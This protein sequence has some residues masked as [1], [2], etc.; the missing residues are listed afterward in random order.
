MPISVRRHSHTML[1]EAWTSLYQVKAFLLLHTTKGFTQHSPLLGFYPPTSM[2]GEAGCSHHC[3]AEDTEACGRDLS[4]PVEGWEEEASRSLTGTSPL[5][6]STVD[7]VHS[8]ISLDLGRILCGNIGNVNHTAA[9][10]HI[11]F[12][13][14]SCICEDLLVLTVLLWAC[15]AAGS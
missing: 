2:Q 14:Y 11:Y 6:S 1:P 9:G 3:S 12:H 5:F 7:T 15:T 8:G 10:V 13:K 4:L